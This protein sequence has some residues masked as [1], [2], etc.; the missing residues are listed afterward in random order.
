MNGCPASGVVPH[1]YETLAGNPACKMQDL[2]PEAFYVDPTGNSTQCSSASQRLPCPNFEDNSNGSSNGR[3]GGGA[4]ARSVSGGGVITVAATGN[5]VSTGVTVETGEDDMT[6]IR[7]TYRPEPDPL[8]S[9]SGAARDLAIMRMMGQATGAGSEVSGPDNFVRAGDQSPPTVSDSEAISGDDGDGD[10]DGGVLSDDP[11]EGDSGRLALVLDFGVDGVPAVW[12][13][14]DTLVESTGE[15]DSLSWIENSVIGVSQ[16]KALQWLGGVNNKVAKWLANGAGAGVL[17]SA[18]QQN[19]L[20]SK[21]TVTLTATAYDWSGRVAW[22]TK[23]R[24]SGV[25]YRGISNPR[26]VTLN[27]GT[28]Y[29]AATPSGTITTGRIEWLNSNTNFN[30][31]FPRSSGGYVPGN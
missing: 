26:T 11:L 29:R 24:I 12:I 1:Q 10:G 21:R 19:A 6:E 13:D 7:N 5:V 22:D 23:G 3:P 16:W 25:D 30:R 2:T 8:A 27:V 9:E 4:V 14:P 15:W 18:L 28:Q 17:I 31:S 20:Y